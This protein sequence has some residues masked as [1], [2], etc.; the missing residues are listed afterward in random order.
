MLKAYEERTRNA[1]EQMRRE[2]ERMADEE[3]MAVIQA[4]LLDD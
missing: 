3:E 2:L 1:L 4:L